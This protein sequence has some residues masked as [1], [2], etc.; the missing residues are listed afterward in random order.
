MNVDKN[1]V[2]KIPAIHDAMKGADI[3][4][5]QEADIPV[6]SLPRFCEAWKKLGYKF[7]AARPD[8][9]RVIRT[10]L[11]TSLAASPVA[12]GDRLDAT[13]FAAALIEVPHANGYFK[14]LAVDFYGFAMD[15]PATKVLCE[16]LF[17]ALTCV[18]LP[19]VSIGD[20][21]ATREELWSVFSQG[22]ARDLDADFEPS[23]TLPPTCTG[24]RRIDWAAGHRLW[25]VKLTHRLGIA[26]HLLLEYHLDIDA[27]QQETIGRPGNV[28]DVVEPA[29]IAQAF[30]ALWKPCDLAALVRQGELQAAWC[31]LSDS[32]E[33]CM[34]SHFDFSCRRT[35]SALPRRQKD[36]GHKATREPE[37]AKL[38]SLRRLLRRLLASRQP[39]V[40]TFRLAQK[41]R[42]DHKRLQRDFPELGTIDLSEPSA[43][44]R[45][46]S[47]VEAQVDR[48]R[49]LRLARWRS[50]VDSS[51][52]FRLAWVRRKVESFREANPRRLASS[53]ELHAVALHPLRVLD[54]AAVEWQARWTAREVDE[55]R[56]RTYL[57]QVPACSP[58]TLDCSFTVE[59]LQQAAR[60]M[61]R[62]APGRDQWTAEELL[63]LPES[64]WSGLVC[65]CEGIF[66]QGAVP[67]SWACCTVSLI[68]KVEPGEHRPIAL[69]PVVWRIIMKVVLR[70]LRPWMDGWLMHFTF[71][72]VHGASVIDSHALLNFENTPDSVTVSQDLTKFYDSIDHSLLRLTL[73][74]YGAPRAFIDVLVDFY[75][76]AS[77]VLVYKGFSLGADGASAL[78]VGRGI[79]QGCPASPM[80]SA[81]FMNTWG[82]VLRPFARVSTFVDDRLIFGR[83]GRLPDLQRAIE[84]SNDFD[85]CVQFECKPKKC[86]VA[87]AAAGAGQGFSPAVVNFAEAV[88]YPLTCKLKV[89][90]LI[91]V[92]GQRGAISMDPGLPAAI[93]LLAKCIGMLPGPGAL[94]GAILK[95]MLIPKLTWCAGVAAYDLQTLRDL[96]YDVVRALHPQALV[97]TPNVLA[98][99]ILGWR[100]EPVGAA[101]LATLRTCIRWQFRRPRW[102]ED[103]GIDFALRPAAAILPGVQSALEA[104]GWWLGPD[105]LSF[106]RRDAHGRL[107]SFV[108]GEDSTKLL[109]LWIE[110]ELS[111]SALQTCSRVAKSLHRPH[112]AQLA[113]GLDLPKPPAD[114]V[115]LAQGHQAVFAGASD[116]WSLQTALAGGCSVW[117]HFPKAALRAEDPRAVCVCGKRLPSRPHLVWACEALQHL[118]P[119]RMPCDRAQERLFAVTTPE[120][121][122]PPAV[123]DP[124]SFAEDLRDVLSAAVERG[125][126][127]VATDGSE[128]DMLSGFAIVVEG[129]DEVIQGGVPGEDQSPFKA[130]VYAMVVLLE[131]L[132]GLPAPSVPTRCTVA[133]DCQAALAVFFGK[134]S[135]LPGLARR[136]GALRAGLHGHWQLSMVWVPS[137]GKESVHFMPP[138]WC[139]PDRLRRLNDRADVAAKQA[140]AERRARSSRPAWI[141]SVAAAKQ[142]EMQTLQ[143]VATIADA[144]ARHAQGLK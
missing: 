23:F 119:P 3:F 52:R 81:L 25:A 121:P 53:E 87:A 48:E 99:Q 13:R 109:A 77:R 69:A 136:L 29:A 57:R 38:R 103:V 142:W 54:K 46:T 43:V 133:V 114:H 139:H 122:P 106:C 104:L 125:P 9:R 4:A 132:A 91:H 120:V 89:L 68:D 141:A 74:H 47:L 11:L 26:N 138:E 127:L 72:G 16:E 60:Q 5:L 92:A 30:A 115:V 56:F 110:Y 19:W 67:R 112:E 76:A 128:K 50:R 71:G 143:A 24:H 28:L 39:G 70:R 101:L 51:S 35:A 63:R 100:H 6:D 134:G 1:G 130:E 85:D 98:L 33:Q 14:F 73:Q 82:W 80:L 18:G 79:L 86:A 108:M 65:L 41:L 17:G 118:R 37:T 107:R 36:L 96:R 84:A 55:D 34:A 61:V 78:K 94:R 131:A 137:H 83:E 7:F 8:E 42:W 58:A 40:D 116:K 135:E 44:D 102:L 15:L 12:L 45:V 124:S 64:W 59:E 126:L 95:Q 97:D 10:G 49:A 20:Y 93:R 66:A 27:A 144:Y 31:Y 32:A 105:S 111:R 22:L 129:M 117:S 140:V 123:L 62:R 113:Q 21:N 88:R 2:A 90:G 75:S